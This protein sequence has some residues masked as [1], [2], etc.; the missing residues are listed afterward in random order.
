MGAT[1]RFMRAWLIAFIVALPLAGVA[2]AQSLADVARQEEA[3]RKAVKTP[4]KVYT[5]E[6]LRPSDMPA[7]PPSAAT[8]APAPAPGTTPAP[9]TPTPAASEDD[10]DRPASAP[11]PP[12][13][14]KYWRGRVDAAR[15]AVSRAQTFQE[16][17]QSRINALSADFVNR[18]DPVQRNVIAGERQKALAELDRVKQEIADGQKAIAA[19]QDEAR[20][21]NVPAGWVR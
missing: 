18:D 17:L 1:L 21:A 5:N 14:E 19:I 16:A 6:S 3:R 12:R 9:G 8:G 4:S 11:A 2:P 10:D 7:A 15:A 20:R 13:D